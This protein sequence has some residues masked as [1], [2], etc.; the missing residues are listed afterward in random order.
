MMA[1]SIDSLSGC[2]F[3]RTRDARDRTSR[4]QNKVSMKLENE[5][6]FPQKLDQTKPKPPV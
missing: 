6:E 5:R 1:P 4:S 2:I 3:G